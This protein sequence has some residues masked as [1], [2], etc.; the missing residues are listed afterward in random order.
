MI[1]CRE[2]KTLFLTDLAVSKVLMII[3]MEGTQMFLHS[4]KE[5]ADSMGVHL[6][7]QKTQPTFESANRLLASVNTFFDEHR[8][9]AKS[10]KKIK[11]NYTAFKKRSAE[12]SCS[13]P[14]EA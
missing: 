13:L 5:M 9:N 10:L 2:G 12:P 8:E 1:L 3:P 11:Q 4:L 7:G 6:K 14:H